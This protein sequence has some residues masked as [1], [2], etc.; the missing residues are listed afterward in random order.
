M[1]RPKPA[2]E[3]DSVTGAGHMA[4]RPAV[5]SRRRIPL[6]ILAVVVA[7]A[8]TSVITTAVIYWPNVSPTEHLLAPSTEAPPDLGQIGISVSPKATGGSYEP[9]IRPCAAVGWGPIATHVGRP[10]SVAQEKLSASGPIVT[11]VCSTPLGDGDSRGVAMAE[12]TL[13]EDGSAE[14]MFEGLRRAIQADVVLT[15]ISGLS[16]AAYAYVD[17]D[18]GPAVVAYDGNLYLRLV[19]VPMKPKM[20]P[21]YSGIVRALAEVARQT[22]DSLRV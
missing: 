22:M 19:W 14:D 11:M 3:T 5:K 4:L 6:T 1:L 13:V 2:N 12:I 15:P 21:M 20:L 8:V 18:V 16:A 10:A 9:V 7:I 17:E